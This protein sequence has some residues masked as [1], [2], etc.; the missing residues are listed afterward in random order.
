VQLRA[1]ADGDV[2]RPFLLAR[3]S[4]LS[5]VHGPSLGKLLAAVLVDPRARTSPIRYRQPA[6]ALLEIP[7]PTSDRAD[8]IA[9]GHKPLEAA[10]AWCRPANVRGLGAE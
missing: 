5:D 3:P 8:G 1:I 4:R 10:S 6:P 9:P 7:I 2:P